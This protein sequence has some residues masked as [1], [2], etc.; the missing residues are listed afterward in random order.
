MIGS[1]RVNGF[2]WSCQASSSLRM[3]EIY[4]GV[5]SMSSKFIFVSSPSVF[6]VSPALKSLNPDKGFFIWTFSLVEKTV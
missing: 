2:L 5:I 4:S 1:S 3:K 6:C